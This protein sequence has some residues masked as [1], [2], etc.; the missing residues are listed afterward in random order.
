MNLPITPRDG[1]LLLPVHVQPRASSNSIVDWHDG[2]LKLRLTSPPVDGAANKLCIKF[3]AKSLGLSPS[4][5]SLKSG[6]TSRDKVILIEDMSPT[7]FELKLKSL[8]NT[9]TSKET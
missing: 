7:E 2:R 4:R 6:T 9:S 1:D 3:L 5:V 8:L